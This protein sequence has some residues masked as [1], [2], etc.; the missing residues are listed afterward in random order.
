MIYIIEVFMVF[1]YGRCVG[2]QNEFFYGVVDNAILNFMLIIT[3]PVFF[4]FLHA[5]A[6]LQTY[7][8]HN[9]IIKQS[10]ATNLQSNSHVIIQ[11]QMSK[12]LCWRHIC[13]LLL[14]WHSISYL[15]HCLLSNFHHF[16]ASLSFCLFS[17]L[18]GHVQ[19]MPRHLIPARHIQGNNYRGPNYRWGLHLN[20]F[21][22]A[23]ALLGMLCSACY[24]GI[25]GAH[26][27]ATLLLIV[28]SLYFAFGF[29]YAIK[30][31]FCSSDPICP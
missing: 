30:G 5:F 27:H 6:Y 18:N 4:Y 24:I 25:A 7:A 28:C 2:S 31:L 23:F 14:H 10:M 8:V 1:M 19:H 16:H 21:V 22:F 13:Q 17:N 15:R 12:W 3:Y 20:V 11:S 26:F 29:F 9:R